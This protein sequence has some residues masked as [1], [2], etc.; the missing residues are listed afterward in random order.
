LLA[1]HGIRHL[2]PNRPEGLWKS[3]GGKTPHAT[4]AAAV[5]REIA[6]QEKRSRFRRAE[7][8]KFTRA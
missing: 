1:S 7:A 2:T 6:Q 3:P 4:I 8:G 5:T